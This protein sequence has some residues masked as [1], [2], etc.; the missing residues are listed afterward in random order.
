MTLHV[1]ATT[2]PRNTR[3]SLDS[4]HL[5][6]WR[7]VS[8]LEPNEVPFPFRLFSTARRN[9]HVQESE[10]SEPSVSRKESVPGTYQPPGHF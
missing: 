7:H 4:G 3:D 1:D 2:L 6:G 10:R 5:F 9:L 8:I